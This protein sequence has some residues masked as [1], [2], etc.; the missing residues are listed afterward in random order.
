MTPENMEG[1]LNKISMAIEDTKGLS[2]ATGIQK[3]LARAEEEGVRAPKSKKVVLDVLSDFVV[4]YLVS[5]YG[6]QYPRQKIDILQFKTVIKKSQNDLNLPMKRWNQA[7]ET[8][9][10]DQLPTITEANK[11]S[12]DLVTFVTEKLSATSIC[13]LEF[14]QVQRC[15]ITMLY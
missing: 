14:I 4:D 8:I 10:N 6:T 1:K 13:E 11:L 5:R 7:R 2:D 9:T 15:L 12:S 3:F